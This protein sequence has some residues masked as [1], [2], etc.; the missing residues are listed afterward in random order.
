[1]R[2]F[3]VMHEIPKKQ[4]TPKTAKKSEKLHLNAKDPKNSPRKEK[5]E[6]H[7]NARDPLES[8]QLLK[9]QLRLHEVDHTF[10]QCDPGKEIV[11]SR[12]C[13]CFPQSELTSSSS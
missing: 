11:K 4:N 3:T 13:D 9:L 6:L 2:N 5:R 12:S 8:A 1:M 10:V 7:L